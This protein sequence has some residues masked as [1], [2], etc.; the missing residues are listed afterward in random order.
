MMIIIIMILIIIM[1][2]II[3]MIAVVTMEAEARTE[4]AAPSASL[5]ELPTPT[6]AKVRCSKK[7]NIPKQCLLSLIASHCACVFDRGFSCVW[8]IKMAKK[9]SAHSVPPVALCLTELLKVAPSRGFS[10]STLSFSQVL[11]SSCTTW[12]SR[13]VVPTSPSLRPWWPTP[14]S[15][16]SLL[17]PRPPSLKTFG[18]L[19][20]ETLFHPFSSSLLIINLFVPNSLIS[21]PLCSSVALHPHFVLFNSEM[22]NVTKDF[23]EPLAHCCVIFFCYLDGEI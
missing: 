6:F 8:H 13:L 9:L 19:Q 18:M 17:S 12:T 16:L 2:I 23:E 5:L 1:I 10:I 11:T 20:T 3:I 21:R 14:P 4:A 22:N 15:C 7:Q